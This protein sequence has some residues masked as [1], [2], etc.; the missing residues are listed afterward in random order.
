MIA[1]RPADP[2]AGQVDFPKVGTSPRPSLSST[3]SR[4]GSCPRSRIARPI[5]TRSTT[6]KTA[7]TWRS[8]TTRQSRGPSSR[9]AR[10]TLLPFREL[11]AF[12]IATRGQ[13]DRRDRVFATTASAT[14][15]GHQSSRACGPACG[16]PP[17]ISHKMRS[18]PWICLLCLPPVALG[19][20]G[21]EKWSA[22]RSPRLRLDD[23]PN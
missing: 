7:P 10:G 3:C 22:E 8:V 11:A 21:L 6:T 19:R 17:S 14:S 20:A 23:R 13:H 16:A 9:R 18:R 1:Q 5:R 4:L 12:T 15:S 2:S